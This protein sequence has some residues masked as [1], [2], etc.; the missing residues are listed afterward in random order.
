MKSNRWGLRRTTAA[1]VA[2]GA[3]AATALV[4]QTSAV[5]VASTAAPTSD[6][7]T[8]EPS[9]DTASS[10]GVEGSDVVAFVRTS[11]DTYQA[12]WQRGMNSVADSNGVSVTFIENN[13]DQTEQNNQVQQQL[14]GGDQPDAWAWMPT[15]AQAGVATLRLLSESGI[16]VFQV[17]Q[18]PPEGSEQYIT[19][20]AGVNDLL[21]GRT[22][23]ELIVQAR[24][25][26]VENGQLGADEDAKLALIKFFPGF[27]AGIDRMAG[28]E[29]VIGDQPFEV[30]AEA[31]DAVD[32]TTGYDATSSIMPIL[33]EKG[34]DILYAQN[35]AGAAGA[36]QALIDGG[37]T[38][39]EDVLVVGGNCRDDVSDLIDGRQ[40]GTGLQAAE[41]E[42]QFTMQMIVNYLA[43]PTVQD[44]E[45]EAP[46][47]PDALPEWPATISK[48]NY[49]PNPPV[50]GT[51]VESTMLW[52][53]SMVDLCSY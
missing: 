39:G 27:Q 34:V 33:T 23:G 20:Y 22:S 24:D 3:L 8:S 52:G 7:A 41:L 30:V 43:N 26:L 44:G 13:A 36:I 53:Q 32:A 40:F 29:S 1:T 35:D 47:T 10:A 49:L 51:E 38:P 16:P 50:L 48:F 6:A 46:A 19:A 4:A 12:A 28:V 25:Q 9:G 37:F 2:F 31:D 14:G 5:G 18:L 21:N 42:G 15:D 45:Y 17:N 11:S